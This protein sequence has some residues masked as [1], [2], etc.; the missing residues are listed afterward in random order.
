MLNGDPQVLLV[1]D[2]IKLLQG[3]TTYTQDAGNVTIE[4]TESITLKVGGTQLTLSPHGMSLGVGTESSMLIGADTMWLQSPR[5]HADGGP[6]SSSAS[7]HLEESATLLGLEVEVTSR[8]SSL[9]LTN[10]AVLTGNTVKL[11]P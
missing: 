2:C 4:A 3:A 11:N 10:D 6:R 7:L 5:F 1:P 8:G 9:Q